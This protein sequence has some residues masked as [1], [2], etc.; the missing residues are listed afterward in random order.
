MSD[1]KVTYDPS[2]NVT[3]FKLETPEAY[4]AFKMG[5]QTNDFRQW[6]RHEETRELQNVV[7]NNQRHSQ[8][9]VKYGSDSLLLK[10]R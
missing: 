1:E 9:V 5:Y 7:V 10:N 2:N 8:I 3:T 6:Q 4:S